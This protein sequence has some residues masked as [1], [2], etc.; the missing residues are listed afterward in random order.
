MKKKFSTSWKASKKPRKQRKYL[1]NAP[2]HTKRKMMKVN[3]S[4][5]LRK[6]QGKRSIL[7]RNG[8]IVL[9]KRGK[10]RGKKGKV[11]SVKL[12]LS[13]VE[14]EGTQIKKQDGSKVNVGMK[15]WNLQIVELNT[16]ER[17]RKR[18]SVKTPEKKE[19][20]KLETEQVEKPKEVKS[21]TK[22][23]AS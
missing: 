7:I 12:K 21:G 14:V 23:N 13:R 3:L 5:E 18:I 17:K 9:I 10:F 22:E 8:D 11:L 6:S 19:E 2:L 4:K 20:K 16:E 15:P 1:A